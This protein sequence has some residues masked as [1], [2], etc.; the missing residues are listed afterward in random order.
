MAFIPL[1]YTALFTLVFTTFSREW[2]NNIF[3]KDTD[4]TAWTATTLETMAD[5]IA[6]WYEAVYDLT[7]G[8][9]TELT[10][11]RAYSQHSET[12]PFTVVEV[13]SA[14]TL[15]GSLLPLSN[16][17][18]VTLQS[19]TRGRSGRGRVYV[20]GIREADAVGNLVDTSHADSV[21]AAWDQLMFT[22]IP[23]VGAG[24]YRP[25]VA[26]RHSDGSPLLFGI[27]H[28]LA[29]V[30]YSSRRIYSQRRRTS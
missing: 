13:G 12:A 7:T 23:A 11:I 29:S 10:R 1:E 26:Q 30:R 5:A 21:V 3:I 25:V 8:V 2:T 16:S 20:T 18:V 17:L 19:D 22:T 15:V 27:T 24:T 9:D 28:E 4:E 6:T 14:G